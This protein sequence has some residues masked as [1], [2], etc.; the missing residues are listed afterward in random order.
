MNWEPIGDQVLVKQHAKQD[1][2]KSGIILTTGMDDFLS[3]T[4]VATGTGLFTQ[5]GDRIPVTVKVGDHVVIHK[6][7]VGKHK[8]I[9]I[10]DVEY[11]L[12]RESEI[13]LVNVQ[14]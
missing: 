13:A 8:R 6:N 12:I 11:L 14:K 2:T 7:E 1:K 4:V 9:T 3:C 10:D 5:T